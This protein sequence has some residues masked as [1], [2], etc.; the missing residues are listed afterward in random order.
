M[1][2]NQLRDTKS[3]TKNSEVPTLPNPT[4]V[5][6]TSSPPDIDLCSLNLIHFLSY[7]TKTSL[8]SYNP[9]YA[10]ITSDQWPQICE[11]CD[12]NVSLIEGIRNPERVCPRTKWDFSYSRPAAKGDLSF[13]WYRFF[14]C[15][16]DWANGIPQFRM[17]PEVDQEQLLR[18]NF[19]TLSVIIFLNFLTKP[20]VDSFRVPLGN[21]AY[22]DKDQV[23]RLD[24]LHR[25]IMHAYIEHLI[26]PL[27]NIGTDNSEFAII[28]AI[29]L[30]QYNEG[31]SPEGRKI[32]E[33]YTDKLYDA[34]Y[35][36]QRIR[37]P[38]SPS[39]ERTR[40]QTKIL[41]IMAKMPQIW[42]AESDIH[43]M[44]STFDQMNIDGIPKELLFYRFG[45]KTD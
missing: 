2:E 39:K 1:N 41:M 23:G 36:Y 5:A 25:T 13:C 15:I 43:L 33:D 24:E 17:L 37:F 27:L 20:N 28:N 19:T 22:V 11:K 10:E 32:A 44:L 38:N 45:L 6:S 4:P 9:Q 14:V 31:L 40:R 8:E 3:Y 7:M 35:D 34:L 42:A 26:K 12:R 30:F 16:A 21:G 29:T 18:L